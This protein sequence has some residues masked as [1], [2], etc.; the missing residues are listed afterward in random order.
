MF[1]K[2]LTY[3]GSQMA[4]KWYRSFD[5]LNLHCHACILSIV[6]VLSELGVGLCTLLYTVRPVLWDEGLRFWSYD[7]T[8][9]DKN[10]IIVIIV[11]II[12]I[13]Y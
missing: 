10:I 7:L 1:P 2:I 5:E 8:A 12:I 9:L 3:F 6:A 11:V 4:K 13:I